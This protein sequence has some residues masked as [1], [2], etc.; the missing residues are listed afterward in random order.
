MTKGLPFKLLE[1][2]ESARRHSPSAFSII[3]GRRLTWRSCIV[4]TVVAAVSG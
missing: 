3:Q 1:L 2:R 4:A